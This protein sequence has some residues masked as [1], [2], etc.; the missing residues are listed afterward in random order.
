M[1][2]RIIDVHCH[3]T[4]SRFRAAVV[5]E[6][7]EWHG[8]T[9]A[10]GELGNPKNHWDVDRRLQEM[11]RLRIDV[12][13]VSP[14]D[15]F[16]QYDREPEV[17]ERIAREANEE[18]AGMARDHPD[19]FMG[20]GTLPMQDPARAV[21]E[22]VRGMGEL[23]L[24]GFMV[25][26]H[27]NGVTYDDARFEA[28]WEAAESLRAFLLIHQY[29]HTTV[30]LRTQRYFLLN[31]IGN[32]ADRTITFASF[33]Y[34]GVLDR[35]PG[36]RIC[37]AHGGGYVPYALD[38]LDKGWDVWPELRGRSQDRPSSYAR[39]FYYDTV[40]YTSRNLRFL[41]DV[42]G[43]DRVVFGTDWPAPMTFDDP[44]G[45]LETMEGLSGDERHA[46]L[47]GTAASLFDDPGP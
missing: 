47:R 2:T 24:S 4:L 15:V 31:S 3:C 32:L 46:L 20:L 30:A 10:D 36:L 39:R 34:G 45:R 16:Y 42:V 6:R 23:G 35:H 27:V 17:T 13:L 21:A 1:T 38:R 28:V 44:V 11:D 19:R 9:A 8:M 12:Q 41:V 43:A 14:T 37:L 18:I 25:D 40:V 22:L 5:D 26:D 29:R 33:V 7:R